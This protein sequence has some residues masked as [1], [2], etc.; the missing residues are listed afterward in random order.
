MYRMI[1]YTQ[2]PLLFFFLK[3]KYIKIINHYI[4]IQT[5][6]DNSNNPHILTPKLSS[7]YFVLKN[8]S[9]EQHGSFEQSLLQPCRMCYQIFNVQLEALKARQLFRKKQLLIKVYQLSD[10]S[11]SGA[12]VHTVNILKYLQSLNKQWN[13]KIARLHSQKI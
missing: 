11:F 3:K 2:L 8:I 4:Q 13:K 9:S 12:I 10:S 7:K 5:Y 6:M 1:Y